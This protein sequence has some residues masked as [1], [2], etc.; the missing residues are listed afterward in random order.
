MFGWGA[1]E[2]IQTQQ[3]KADPDAAAKA[4]IARKIEAEGRGTCQFCGEEILKNTE[5]PGGGWTWESEFM[6]GW[7]DGSKDK[8]HKP[9]V[10]WTAEE[11]VQVYLDP[12]AEE[13][14][15]QRD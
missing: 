10:V 9:K 7:C 12:T 3:A 8:K 13:G 15:G 11:G 2:G 14:V 6:L 5:M 1:F 4:E